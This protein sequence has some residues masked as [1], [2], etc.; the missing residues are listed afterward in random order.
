MNDAAG[1]LPILLAMFTLKED[2]KR[3][4]TKHHQRCRE[5]MIK[6]MV[7]EHQKSKNC[8]LHAS[9]SP[10]QMKGEIALDVL[11]KSYK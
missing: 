10:H 4:I 3:D 1:I 5:D 6:M 9:V 2:N 7:L 8:A 11:E